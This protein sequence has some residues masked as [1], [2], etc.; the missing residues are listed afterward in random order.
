MFFC[1]KILSFVRTSTLQKLTINSTFGDICLTSMTP[2]TI[3]DIIQT[4]IQVLVTAGVNLTP[5]GPDIES[6]EKFIQ[7]PHLTHII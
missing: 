6:K 1:V 7:S 3:T 5:L 4:V 2:M